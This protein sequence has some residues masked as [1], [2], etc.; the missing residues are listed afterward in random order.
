MPLL[1]PSHCRP[2][3]APVASSPAAPA[4]NVVLPS[5]CPTC[6]AAWFTAAEDIFQLWSF[7]DQR[8]MFAYAYTKQK[9]AQI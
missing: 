7:T 3:P 4:L 8:N 9:A 1:L 6:P 2:L 5:F